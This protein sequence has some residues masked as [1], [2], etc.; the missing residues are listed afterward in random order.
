MSVDNS[1][2]SIRIEPSTFIE[3]LGSLVDILIHLS[4]PSL[5]LQNR[6]STLLKGKEKFITPRVPECQI[7]EPVNCY[8]DIDKEF[9][10]ALL[11]ASK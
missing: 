2:G 5:F 6:K 8:C 11:Q 7:G 4:E 9:C 3:N 1:V 10:G